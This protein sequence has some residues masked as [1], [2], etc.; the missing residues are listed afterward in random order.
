MK[1]IESIVPINKY[2]RDGVKLRKFRGVTVHET[3][4]FSKGANAKSHNAYY[5]NLIKNGNTTHIGY[6]YF[7]DDKEIYHVMPDDERAW[8]CGDGADGAGNNETVSVEMCVNPDCNKQTARANT[9][10]LV[11]HILKQ[12][13]IRTV[14]DGVK[15][16][17]NGNVFQHYSWANK[18]CP[19]VMIKEGYWNTFIKQVE[20]NLAKLWG[21]TFP[22]APPKP[23]PST[24]ADTYTVKRGDSW[25]SIAAKQLGKGNR[26]I[27][28]AQFNGKKTT[29]VIRPGDVLKLPKK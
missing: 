11:A 3:G 8:T 13:N 4:N 24:V 27:E 25:W 12:H 18:K 29:A 9:A 23:V 19:Y 1:I 2:H 7:V 10:Y 26:Y 22:P 14:I 16:K 5:H 21:V 28:L 20:E 15:S 17:A 6:H